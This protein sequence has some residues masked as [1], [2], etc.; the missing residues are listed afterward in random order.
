MFNDRQLLGLEH[1]CRLIQA[2]KN[3]RIQKA[4]AT[5]LSDLLRYQ[6]ML[7][8]YDAMALK[9]LDIFSVHG[10]PVG[11]IHVESNLLGVK[12]PFSGL[13]VGSGGWHNIIEKYA[14]AKLYCEKP[15]E[16]RHKAT[17][18]VVV[19]M[20]GEWIGESRNSHHLL[21][22]RFVMV[23][24][25]DSATQKLEQESLDAVF[26]DP[27]Y[28]GNIQYSELMDFCY[29]WLRKLMSRCLEFGSAST[30]RGEE[31]TGNV[32][33]GRGIVHFT[34]GL[35]RVFTGMA[36][37]LKKG[38]PLAFTFHHNDI[39]AYFPVAVAVLDSKLI[40]SASLP[41]PAEMGASIHIA[42]TK[43]SIVDT[44]FVCRS[45]GVVP[46]K[47]IPDDFQ[48][49][50]ELIAVDINQLEG[51]GVKPT[52]GDAKCTAYGHLIRLAI[53]SLRRDW[54]VTLPTQ[55][56]LDRGNLWLRNCCI[57]GNVLSA[58]GPKNRLTVRQSGC[59]AMEKH[60]K[61]GDEADEI[62]F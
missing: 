24:C 10:F 13:P 41:C 8:R 11:L 1:S 55:V 14:K 28:F 29:V 47:W 27:P 3:E 43:S 25:R 19:P 49:L 48:S 39:N 57:L 38:G 32:T 54:D 35:L 60:A 16:I 22:S 44:V 20:V 26:T 45:T 50:V 34:E 40:C 58:L 2:V 61:Y 18:K 59:L 37:A 46:S 30:M 31:L 33:A 62:L 36:Y 23:E 12:N 17:G 7:C 5:N 21:D 9:S 51:G 6:N 42:G 15:F 53:W 56:K 52:E 4:L